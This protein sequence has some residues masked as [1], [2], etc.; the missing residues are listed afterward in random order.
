[1]VL[2][3]YPLE[4]EC[5]VTDANAAALNRRAR[6]LQRFYK[7]TLNMEPFPGLAGEEGW[8]LN[9]PD[10]LKDT[11]AAPALTDFEPY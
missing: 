9:L 8:M 10:H 1:M 6:A 11:I 3:A 7:R 5:A 4:Y 2:K